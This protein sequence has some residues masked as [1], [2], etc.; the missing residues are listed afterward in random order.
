MR[1]AGTTIEQV[2]AVSGVGS[3][4]LEGP[5]S[6]AGDPAERGATEAG[7]SAGRVASAEMLVPHMS[8]VWRV[9]RGL[10]V[11]E[12][13]V[14]DATQRVFLIVARKLQKVRP[15]AERAYLFSTAVRMASLLRRNER[16]RSMVGEIEL[17]D[18]QDPGLGPDEAVERREALAL[19]ERILERMPE[20]IRLVFLL[21]DVEEI[22]AR[23]VSE[24]LQIPPGTVAS[25]LR[26]A[27]EELRE[28]IERAKRAARSTPTGRSE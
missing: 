4:D 25:R 5:G 3:G 18:R 27:R 1:D 12:S 13:E 7:D 14:E 26:R 9:L 11:R 17:A 15:G 28:G 10:G 8:F 19:L 6:A 21:C 24:L 20:E 16:R 23:E 22:T 2:F